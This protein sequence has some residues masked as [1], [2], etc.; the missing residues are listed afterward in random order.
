[1]TGQAAENTGSFWYIKTVLNYLPDALNL[2]PF[3]SASSYRR[4]LADW[5]QD[6]YKKQACPVRIV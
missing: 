6:E 1:M 3:W 4:E 5:L 2:A